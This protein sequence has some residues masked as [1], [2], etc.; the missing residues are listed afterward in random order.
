MKAL[1]DSVAGKKVAVDDLLACRGM[2]GVDAGRYAEALYAQIDCRAD[3]DVGDVGRL[4]AE[5]AEVDPDRAILKRMHDWRLLDVVYQSMHR[6]RV[7]TR[8]VSPRPGLAGRLATSRSL[9]RFV[10]DDGVTK[11]QCSMRFLPLKEHA[12]NTF[13]NLALAAFLIY[14]MRPD[15]DW[16]ALMSP[17]EW[18]H[19]EPLAVRLSLL[20]VALAACHVAIR[21]CL[22]L[23]R[24]VH[25]RTDAYTNEVI[26]GGGPGVLLS[27]LADVVFDEVTY[28]WMAIF[29]TGL[30]LSLIDLAMTHY[31]ASIVAMLA[32]HTMHSEKCSLRSI[33]LVS[34]VAAVVLYGQI[35][36][37]S[38]LWTISDAVRSGL[39]RLTAGACPRIL[40][41]GT[42]LSKRPDLLMAMTFSGILAD[43]SLTLSPSAL[44]GVVHE[45]RTLLLS[46]IFWD[47]VLEHG[48]ATSLLLRI[49][50][51][52]VQFAL[53]RL[54]HGPVVVDGVVRDKAHES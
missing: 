54:L 20:G 40:R 41:P 35:A 16:P 25:V 21:T 23:G 29:A 7:F 50:F 31:V 32:V 45:I 1:A 12:A 14:T 13:R 26:K 24:R 30:L 27:T 47:I 44:E 37:I 42:R 33:A 9:R 18:G 2:D 49:W 48:L 19:V 3:A 38:I 11:H 52:V 43:P 34:A 4:W 46:A 28:R 17:P 10:H 51:A 22:G 15:V 8:L 53:A 6:V 5:S 39:H 36:R